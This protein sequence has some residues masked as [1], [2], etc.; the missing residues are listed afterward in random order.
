MVEIGAQGDTY[1][2]ITSG[3]LNEG[4]VLI[5]NVDMGSMTD[6]SAAGSTGLMDGVY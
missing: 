1:T 6:N 2:A 3:N 4:D 5:E